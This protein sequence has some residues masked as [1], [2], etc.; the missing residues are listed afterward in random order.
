MRRGGLLTRGTRSPE[1]V[2]SF[3]PPVVSKSRTGGN[4]PRSPSMKSSM[5]S[6]APSCTRAAS[7]ATASSAIPSP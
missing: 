5:A 1:A 4:S 7:A 6:A 2:V 3:L